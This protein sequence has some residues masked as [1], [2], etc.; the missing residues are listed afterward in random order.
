MSTMTVNQLRDHLKQ[1]VATLDQIDADGG[2]NDPV[3][4]T[5]HVD[6]DGAELDVCHNED[7]IIL[8]LWIDPEEMTE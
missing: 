3:D 8:D 1:A 5:L 4:F 7:K 6:R 2:G